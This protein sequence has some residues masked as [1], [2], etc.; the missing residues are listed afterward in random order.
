MPSGQCFGSTDPD[1]APAFEVNPDPGPALK[2]N[3][4]PDPG[5]VMTGPFTIFFVTGIHSFRHKLLFTS[6][7]RAVMLKSYHAAY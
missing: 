2:V 3:T 4:D 6:A 7:F 1:P 5:F